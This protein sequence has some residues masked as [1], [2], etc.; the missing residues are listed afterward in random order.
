MCGDLSWSKIMTPYWDHK[1]LLC[2]CLT[3][4]PL[5]SFAK[6]RHTCSFL[7]LLHHKPLERHPISGQ[8]C[9]VLFASSWY[10]LH[11]SVV[12]GLLSTLSSLFP[13][14]TYD[15]FLL[16]SS[17]NSKQPVSLVMN[18]PL[19]CFSFLC[20]FQF[21]DLTG[22]GGRQDLSH[23]GYWPKDPSLKPNVPHL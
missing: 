19:P 10:A 2:G 9:L 12:T 5:Q 4:W 20:R 6:A 21:R 11:W 1:V 15:I 16:L 22:M 23:T 7:G 17:V 18:T 13:R 14:R 3:G 8:I